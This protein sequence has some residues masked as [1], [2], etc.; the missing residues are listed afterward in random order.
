MFQFNSVTDRMEIL[1]RDIRLSEIEISLKVNMYLWQIAEFI[2]KK[3][4]I[5]VLICI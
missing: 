3:S 4:T 5:Y 1:I 2:N